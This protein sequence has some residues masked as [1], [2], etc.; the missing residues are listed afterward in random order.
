MSRI[1]TSRRI[2][3]ASS[4]RCAWQPDAVGQLRQLGHD[5][6]DFRHPEPGNEGFSWEAIDPMWQCWTPEQFR[7]GLGHPIAQAGFAFDMKALRACE[8][9]LL[10]LPCY[11]SA[12]LELGW[13]AGAGKHTAVWFPE[14]QEPELMYLALHRILVGLHELRAWGA[15][16]DSELRRGRRLTVD[17]GNVQ[18]GDQNTMNVRTRKR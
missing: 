11:R 4:W 17:G 8:A 12:H 6:Y 7:E 2:Y 10:V 9:C 18:I 14:R 15:T 16:L 13:A 1:R 5:V 3:V